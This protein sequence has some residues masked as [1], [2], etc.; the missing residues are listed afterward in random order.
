MYWAPG[1]VHGPHHVTAAWADKYKGKFDQGWDK[2]RE[3]TYANQK[4]LG[5]IPADTKLTARPNDIEAWDSLSDEQRE[6]FARMMEVYAAALSHADHQMGRILDA[7]SRE[8]DGTLERLRAYVE[9]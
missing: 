2:Q 1:G 5:V 3:L 4:R 6:V 8:W 7:I 9:P